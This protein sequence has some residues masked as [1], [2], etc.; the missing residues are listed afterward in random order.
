MASVQITAW[1]VAELLGLR[2]FG[3]EYDEH[4]YYYVRKFEFHGKEIVDDNWRADDNDAKVCVAQDLLTKIGKN[5]SK[6]I[7]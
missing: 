1:D 7:D 4:K 6:I 5:L 2:Y 3:E